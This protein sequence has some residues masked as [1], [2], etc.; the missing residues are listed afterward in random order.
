MKIY[1]SGKITGEPVDEAKEQFEQ[2]EDTIRFA[3]HEPVN[4]FRVVDQ[5]AKWE[6][7]IGQ[8]VEALLSCDAVF[9]LSNW[10]ASR[11]ALIEV[12]VASQERM[13]FFYQ[14]TY[15][16]QKIKATDKRRFSADFFK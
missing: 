15:I 12:A 10:S 14:S 1:I 5:E 9:L 6:K 4:P 8:C 16:L 7:Q 3:G 11:G 2:A 13:P